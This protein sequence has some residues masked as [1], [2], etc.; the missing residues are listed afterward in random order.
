MIGRYEAKAR[1][2]SQKASDQSR[3]ELVRAAA[4]HELFGK[5]TSG[6]K[7]VHG[8]KF[9]DGVEDLAVFEAWLVKMAISE[10]LPPFP[11]AQVSP[12]KKQPGQTDEVAY[13][14]YWK[15]FATGQRGDTP[16]GS[17]AGSTAASSEGVQSAQTTPSPPTARELSF[18]GKG[19]CI[20]SHV[21]LTHA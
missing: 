5:F 18:E 8:G 15:Q 19:F 2:W 3:S 11:A 20:L 12:V 17:P 10:R 7:M 4:K 6:T 13:Q 1:D 9:G 14:Q 21:I 16:V